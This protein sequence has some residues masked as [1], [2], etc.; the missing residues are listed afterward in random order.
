MTN[1]I[2]QDTIKEI[3]EIKYFM[4]VSPLSP[5]EKAELELRIESLEIAVEMMR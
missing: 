4:A 3:N 2:K 5:S 1:N